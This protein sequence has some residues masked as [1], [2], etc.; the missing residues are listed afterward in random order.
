MFVGL[1][2]TSFCIIKVPIVATRQMFVY[3]IQ[4]NLIHTILRY[5]GYYDFRDR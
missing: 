3:K 1:L 4:V 2:P 5:G